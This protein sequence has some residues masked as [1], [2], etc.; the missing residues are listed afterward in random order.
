MRYRQGLLVIL[1]ASLAACLPVSKPCNP[2]PDEQVLIVS[3]QQVGGYRSWA[4]WLVGIQTPQ[5]VKYC[6][7]SVTAG[8]PIQVGQR[9]FL[10][11]FKQD[12][13]L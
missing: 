1:L 12:Y 6:R 3:A 10:R 13:D 9:Y 5:G 2:K 11:G 7:G 8:I 4:D